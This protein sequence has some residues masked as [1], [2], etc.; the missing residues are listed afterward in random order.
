MNILCYGESAER[1]KERCEFFQGAGCSA[2]WATEVNVAL[3]LLVSKP[4]DSVV[5]GR[6][7]PASECERL[8]EA[9]HLIRPKVEFFSLAAIASELASSEDL[10]AIDQASLVCVY[11]K[12]SGMR[13]RPSA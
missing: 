7:I 10:T 9:M 8:A 6:T 3:A 11:R 2:E 5:F 1:Q 12:L 13:P 4:F